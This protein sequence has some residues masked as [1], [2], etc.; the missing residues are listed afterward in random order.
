MTPTETFIAHEREFDEKF[1]KVP[2]PEKHWT[3]GT[4]LRPFEIKGSVASIRYHIRS[5][6]LAVLRA[7]LAAI[8]E[9]RNT[10][11]N[12]ECIWHEDG[13]YC[14]CSLPTEIKGQNFEKALIRQNLQTTIDNIEKL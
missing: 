13:N 4:L 12:D 11:H 3:G 10:I 1:V 7:E 14:D 9:E 8:G 5:T 2:S 6:V